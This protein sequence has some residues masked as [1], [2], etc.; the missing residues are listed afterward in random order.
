MLLYDLDDQSAGRFQVL[1]H[2]QSGCGTV[3]GGY[4]AINSLVLLQNRMGHAG[5]KHLVVEP[6]AEHVSEK[7]NRVLQHAV[8]GGGGEGEVECEI[9]FEDGVAGSGV[10]TH[11]VDGCAQFSDVRFGTALGRKTGE[12]FL[13]DD[14][15]FHDLA[16]LVMVGASES[17]EQGASEKFRARADEGAVP[18]AAIE[19]ADQLHGLEGFA[20]GGASNAELLAEVAFRRQ[21]VA[22]LPGAVNDVGDELLEGGFGKGGALDGADGFYEAAPRAV[23]WWPRGRRG[24]YRISPLAYMTPARGLVRHDGGR[25]GVGWKELDSP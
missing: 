24:G 12:A 25:S 14:P 7:L 19:H 9:G 20:K 13:D 2:G 23:R 1:A 22:G 5:Q 15:G 8:A 6:L 4:G 3:M 18:D 16:E 21:A 10:L 17:P 11:H